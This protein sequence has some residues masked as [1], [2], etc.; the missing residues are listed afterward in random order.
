MMAIS[1]FPN[2]FSILGPNSPVGSL[3]LHHAAELSSSYIVR[4][5]ERFAG[6]EI[7]SVEPTSEATAEFNA[8]VAKALGPTV[9]NTG[10]NSWYQ[11]ADGT[12]DL[13]PFNRA[14]MKRML[15]EHEDAHFHL[16]RSG[17]PVG[18]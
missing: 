12:I 17:Q 10:C 2:L 5:L 6:G 16:V 7:D 11:R 8:E 3:P 9:W 1:G 14:T 4:W 13:F 18:V 15:G